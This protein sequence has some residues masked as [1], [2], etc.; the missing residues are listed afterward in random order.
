VLHLV[1]STP[2]PSKPKDVK[3]ARLEFWSWVKDLE[4]EN[5]VV[6]LYPRVGR[7]AAAIFD[8]PSNDELH[9]IITQ[10]LNLIP[11]KFDIYPLV[12]PSEAKQLLK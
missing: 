7:G 5:K 3:N 4:S 8:V 10:W 6:C 9:K 11:A 12:T 1:I 2:Y